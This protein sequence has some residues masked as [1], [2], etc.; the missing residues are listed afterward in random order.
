MSLEVRQKAEMEI[1]RL[2]G[3]TGFP[4]PLLRGFAGIPERTWR[5]WQ[6]GRGVRARHH[7]NIPRGYYLTA[8]ETEAMVD[9]CR[10]AA[11]AILRKAAGRCAG[12]WRIKTE[13][14][15]VGSSVYNV[16]NRY[17]PAKKRDELGT[18]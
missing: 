7:G 6:K 18:A 14:E 11:P 2:K 3:K 8:E 13:P 4:L 17:N 15:W 1:T 12:R 10:A 16:I 5:E 9:Y